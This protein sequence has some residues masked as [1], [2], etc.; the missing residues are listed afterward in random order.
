MSK[1]RRW[2]HC[3]ASPRARPILLPKSGAGHRCRWRSAWRWRNWRGM[4]GAPGALSVVR[5]DISR[6]RRVWN[7]GGGG[8][9]IWGGVCGTSACGG[10][11]QWRGARHFSGGGGTSWPPISA[12][13]FPWGSRTAINGNQ[14]SS[15]RNAICNPRRTQGAGSRA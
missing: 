7:F 14:F 12:G 6:W 8:S 2:P 3:L 11:L 15:N 1:P 10:E 4:A 9:D 13:G 5:S